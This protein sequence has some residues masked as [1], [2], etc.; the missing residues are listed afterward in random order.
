VRGGGAVSGSVPNLDLRL[1]AL[2]GAAD[3]VM[4]PPAPDARYDRDGGRAASP[5]LQP[6]VADRRMKL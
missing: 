3:A 4:S 1:E 2:D 5:N 6:M